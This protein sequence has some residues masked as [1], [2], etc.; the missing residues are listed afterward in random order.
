M[1][2][3]NRIMMPGPERKKR[4]H[5]RNENREHGYED[6]P[7]KKKETT[8]DKW[9]QRIGLWRQALKVKETTCEEWNTEEDY[10]DW[11]WKKLSS[12]EE[13]TQRIDLW[14]LTGKEKETICDKWTESRIMKA[15]P[16]KNRPIGSNGHRQQDYK[17][18]KRSHK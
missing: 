9:T 1:E 16:E 13:W 4:L 5:V 15:S 7:W 6:W 12:C 3:E 2:V 14:R 8:S 18:I 11:P 17:I 10:E